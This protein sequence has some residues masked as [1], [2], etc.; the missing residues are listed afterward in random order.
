MLSPAAGPAAAANGA[1]TGPHA[2]ILELEQRAFRTRGAKAA[3]IRDELGMTP[4]GYYQALNGAID[5][6]EAL[7]SHPVLVNRLRARRARL[8]A[9]RTGRANPA[10]PR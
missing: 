9:L 4:T 6:P 2:R 7:Q 10:S 1:L 8:L 3:A 5:T